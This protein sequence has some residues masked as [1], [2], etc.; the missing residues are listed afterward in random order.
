VADERVW[1]HGRHTKAGLGRWR[2]PLFEP[3]TAPRAGLAMLS[4]KRRMTNLALD[5]SRVVYQ[6]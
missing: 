3:P 5:G 1:I 4:A 6:S 2:R